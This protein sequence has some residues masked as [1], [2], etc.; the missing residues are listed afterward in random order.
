MD[1]ALLTLILYRT[2]SADC[3]AP[4]GHLA[5]ALPIR[6]DGRPLLSAPVDVVDDRNCRL[7][8]VQATTE[9]QSH[10]RFIGAACDVHDCWPVGPVR[11]VVTEPAELFAQSIRA[12]QYS[13]EP[14]DRKNDCITSLE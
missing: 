1:S 10:Y 2:V 7:L 4:D 14:A 11:F 13:P 3:A 8:F 5:A 9:H 6:A 12:A